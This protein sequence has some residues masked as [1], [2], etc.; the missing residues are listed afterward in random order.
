VKTSQTLA[1]RNYFVRTT[2]FHI[3]AQLAGIPVFG[4]G[5]LLLAWVVA[6]VAMSVWMLRRPGG[7]RELSGSLPIFLIVAAV[8]GF[9][10]PNLVE[11]GPNGLVLGLPV[12]GYGVML[13]LATVSAVALAAYRAR[14]VG[15]DPEAIYSL[16]F[17]MFLAGIVGARAFYV[18]QYWSQEFSPARTG[19][20]IRTVQAMVNVPKG[21]LVVYGSVLF[22]VPAGF[23]YCRRRGLPALAIGDSIA[24][25]MLVGLALGRVGCFLNGCCFGGVCLTANY[26]VT[27]PADSPPFLQQAGLGWHTGVWLAEQGGRVVAAYVAPH[28]GAS[29]AGLAAGDEII[30][31][32]GARV[33]SLADARE[34]LAGAHA[35]LEIET[36]GG[37]VLSWLP[38]KGPPRSV[39][40]HPAQ[41]YAAL[42]AGLLALVL[43]LYFPFR[44]R[45]GEVF[46]LLLTVH[47]VS[48]FLLEMIRNDE[49]G[50]LGT[51][52]TISQWLSLAILAC[53]MGLWIYLERQPRG[54][55]FSA[56]TANLK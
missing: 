38:G 42:D 46:A 17:V 2:L 35:A 43:W 34:K 20:L 15:L 16:A 53:G 24:P 28:C 47:P 10:L 8:I 13:M 21:G 32:S 54:L 19:S 40:V 27:F 9:V 25:S 7:G 50:W 33:M 37:R 22:G 26:A 51:A 6:C 55:A 31:I 48:R 18:L 45:D 14:Q 49:S 5:W 39:P 1:L 4:F 44:R 56:A 11:A 23:W 52:L 3:P 29:D 41:L 36:T 12:R 30:R